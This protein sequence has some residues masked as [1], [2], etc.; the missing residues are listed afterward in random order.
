MT[1]NPWV[2]FKYQVATTGPDIITPIYVN[3][4]KKKK[5]A[6]KEQQHTMEADYRQVKLIRLIAKAGMKDRKYKAKHINEP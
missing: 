5:L 4:K 1:E 2:F 3:K 6:W